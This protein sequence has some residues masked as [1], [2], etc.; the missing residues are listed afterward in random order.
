MQ[1]SPLLKLYT[2][3]SPLRPRFKNTIRSFWSR[4]TS[5][6]ASIGDLRP[7]LR[8]SEEVQDALETNKPIVALESTIYTHGALGDLNL[9]D[10]VRQHGGVPAVCGILAGEPTVGLSPGEIDRMVHESAQKVSRRD[11]ATLVGLAANG[12]KLHGGTTIAGTMILA[13]LAGIRVFGT[14]GLGGVHR[15]GE[16]SLDISADLS[17]LGRTRMAVVASGCKGFLDIP[18][19]LEYLETQGV[20]VSTFSQGRDHKDVAF[21]AFWAQDSDVKSPSVVESEEEA[22]SIILAQEKFG[23]ESGMVFANPIPREFSIPKAEMNDIIERAVSEAATLQAAQGNENTP[24]ILKRVRELSQDRSVLANTALVQSNVKFATKISV[25]LSRLIS[26]G[27]LDAG[28]LSRRWLK[29]SRR[30]THPCQP[31]RSSLLHKKGP[32]SRADILVAG[33]V[34]IDLACDYHG[35]NRVFGETPRLHTSN[36]GSILQSIGGVGRNVAL[37]AHRASTGTVRLCSMVGNDHAGAII[38]K[39]LQSTGMDTSAVRQLDQ[40]AHHPSSR[41]AQYV[42]INS[43]DKNLILAIADMKIFQDHHFPNEWNS[44]VT[45]ARPKWLAV[46]ACWNAAGIR[47]WIKAAKTSGAKVAFEPVSQAKSMDLFS[48]QELDSPLHVF[49]SPSVDLA[50]PNQLELEAMYDAANANGYFNDPRWSAVAKGLDMHVVSKSLAEDMLPKTLD[51]D[52]LQKA[53]HLL[54]YIPTVIT[55]LGAKGV[56]L[57]KLMPK[58]DPRLEN[59]ASQPFI[60][61]NV[62]GNESE[63]GGIYARFFPSAEETERVVS[64]NGV[65]DTFLGVILAGLANGKCVEELIDVG[66]KGAVMSLMSVESVSPE[67]CRLRDELSTAA[68]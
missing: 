21:P 25:A 64:V 18:R 56:V 60:I 47:H 20:T 7:I 23:I 16:N 61:K 45:T 51:P 41:T 11:I 59:R 24:F 5:K 33:S 49:P 67:V 31:N 13:R 3:G 22:A 29:T 38:M 39:S 46:D 43:S 52:A 34:A 58:N 27:Q 54:P 4:S 9:E 66:Q 63:T 6:W 36:P 57:L 50:T 30:S 68:A 28:K 12:R 40:G 44:I 1:R 8:I 55:K 35:E 37:A 42:A 2:Q 53:I 62:T 32:S 26:S 10:I 48:S 17:E 15:G 65:G 19:T 14:G